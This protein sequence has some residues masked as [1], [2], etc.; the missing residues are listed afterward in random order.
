MYEFQLS[1]LQCYDVGI[2]YLHSVFNWLW[3][4]STGGYKTLPKSCFKYPEPVKYQFC[5]VLIFA[6]LI[7]L[8]ILSYLVSLLKGVG[9][10]ART[11]TTSFQDL[12]QELSC[13]SHRNRMNCGRGI[14]PP[15]STSLPNGLDFVSEA[16]ITVAFHVP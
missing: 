9:A 13:A 2:H 7:T 3:N 10:K 4:W 6:L 11:R 12:K 8:T 16:D 15:D 14:P 1:S 5:L